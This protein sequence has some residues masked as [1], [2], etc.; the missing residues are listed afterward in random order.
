M[1][2]AAPTV[3]NVWEVIN[4]LVNM[5]DGDKGRE[6]RPG[7]HGTQWERGDEEHYMSAVIHQ[8][9]L[10]YSPQGNNHV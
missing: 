8:S 7:R 9:L 10:I 6:G 2:L 4:Q 5:F 3:G 1:T